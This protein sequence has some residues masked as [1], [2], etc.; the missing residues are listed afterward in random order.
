MISL[1]ELNWKLWGI[2]L[3]CILMLQW[4]L[5]STRVLIYTS[6]TLCTFFMQGLSYL[7]SPHLL[8]PHLSSLSSYLLSHLT[9]YGSGHIILLEILL[10]KSFSEK[11]KARTYI[12]PHPVVSV[13]QFCH[14]T[15]YLQ[16]RD[17]ASH[18]FLWK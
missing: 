17:I 11:N 4:S 18:G 13:L 14:Q 8:S 5:N 15:I 3:Y 7:L 16:D 6:H 9:E 1:R 2:L 12:A 10:C